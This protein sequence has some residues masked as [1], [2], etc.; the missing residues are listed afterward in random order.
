MDDSSVESIL[1]KIV[2]IIDHKIWSK[3]LYSEQEVHDSPDEKASGRPI[4]EHIAVFDHS[5][6]V[7]V[8]GYF[9][10][11]SVTEVGTIARVVEISVCENNEMQIPWS[12]SDSVKLLL[13]FLALRS[14]SGINQDET[15]LG[16]YYVAVADDSA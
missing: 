13:K 15:G 12:A 2:S 8:H 5:G 16:P 7:T 3:P 9:G 14:P 1:R 10:S 11:E 4:L 6:I